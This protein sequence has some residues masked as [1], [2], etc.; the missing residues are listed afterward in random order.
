MKTFALFVL[1]GL[2][3]VGCHSNK[4]AQNPAQNQQQAAPVQGPPP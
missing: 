4:P 2:F 1:A 3:A